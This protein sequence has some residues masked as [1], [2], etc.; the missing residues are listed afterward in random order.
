[1]DGAEVKVITQAASLQR[2]II[3]KLSLIKYTTYTTLMVT[4]KG[5]GVCVCVCVCVVDTSC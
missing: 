5:K 2:Q 1:M 4:L 3:Q